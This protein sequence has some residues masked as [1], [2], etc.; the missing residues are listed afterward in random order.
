MIKYMGC[1]I[2]KFAKQSLNSLHLF[3]SRVFLCLYPFPTHPYTVHTFIL[4]IAFIGFFFIQK[5][6]IIINNTEKTATKNSKATIYYHSQTHSHTHKYRY[7]PYIH[8]TLRLYFIFR[9]IC[10]SSLGEVL[11][12]DTM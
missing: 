8:I 10:Y 5:Y 3:N 6:I 7:T 2:L 9:F 1:L 4:C 11:I 12:Y